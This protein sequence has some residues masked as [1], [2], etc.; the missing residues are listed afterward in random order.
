MRR[1]VWLLISLALG[2]A[3]P[4]WAESVTDTYLGREWN[5]GVMA[6]SRTRFSVQGG[7]LVGHYWVSDDEPFEGELTGFVAGPGQDGRFVWSDRYGQGLLEIRF[8]AD[9]QSF[10]SLWGADAAEP[11]HPGYGVRGA[12]VPGCDNATS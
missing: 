12:A 8:A 6:C 1:T 10:T 5:A 2:A 7:A 11:N 9:G 4:N 3:A